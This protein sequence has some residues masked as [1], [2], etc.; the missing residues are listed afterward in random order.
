MVDESGNEKESAQYDEVISIPDIIT[1]VV[2]DTVVS[3]IPAPVTRNLFKAFG[4]L[5]SAAI[6]FP[7]AFLSGMADERRAETEARIKLINTTAAQI[8]HQ[9]QI[10]PEYAR[11]AVQK[12]GH[13]VLR[14]QVNLDMISQE[15][16][17]DIRDASHSIDQSEQEES[18][19]T[20]S[21]DWLNAFE[22]EARQKSTEEMQ[23]YFGKV[24][25]G[26]IRKPGSFST[27]TVKILA[28]LDQEIANHFAR[29]CSMC[30][31]IASE[32]VRVPSLG[33]NAGSNAL[34]EYGLS[35]A[36]LNLL[37]EH[38][39]I[40]SDYNSWYEYVPCLDAIGAGQQAICW[41]L[42]FQGRHWTLT[43]I[44]KGN[45]GK[46]L[47]IYGVALTKSGRELSKI[48]KVEPMDKYS[49]EL[50]RFFEKQGFRMVEVE[51]GKPRV[52]SINA[53]T[54]FR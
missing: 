15:A 4:Q 5:C 3:G 49:Q 32:N 54:G 34:Q 25:A 29:F 39:L 36:I 35:F 21:D 30:I 28:S 45:V 9:M 10:D 46:K 26:E 50:A 43:P 41:P 14:E 1:D 19:T 24:L 17:I 23:V 42:N 53:A 22:T 20:I 33:G 2:A 6:D 31:S 8:A 27:R 38:G 52:V 13:R 51:D 44:S 18:G 37:N 47:K 48:V 12:F 40:I 16:A 7:V 11:V